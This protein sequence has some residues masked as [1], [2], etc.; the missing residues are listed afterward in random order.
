MGDVRAWLS[1]DGLLSGDPDCQSL[2][3]P[4]HLLRHSLRG[5]QLW[6]GP[7]AELVYHQMSVGSPPC[8]GYSSHCSRSCIWQQGVTLADFIP[9]FI[10][11][12]Q[13]YVLSP[14][15]VLGTVLDSGEAE[16]N[17][18][19]GPSYCF[20]RSQLK[21]SLKCT[22]YMKFLPCRQKSSVNG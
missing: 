17:K 5:L 15:S 3:F 11:L 2:P 9:S 19:M 20:S 10:S 12:I 16:M 8:P 1:A 13:R 18:W 21:K 22:W 6:Q 14:V 7:S 4:A